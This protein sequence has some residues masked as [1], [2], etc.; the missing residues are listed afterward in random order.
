MTVDGYA[1]VST[2]G[3]TLDAQI[4]AFKAAERRRS[5]A[6]SSLGLRRIVAPSA[7]SW[8]R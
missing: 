2:D 4:A 3:Q 5:T 7:A 1:R 8:L 6:R